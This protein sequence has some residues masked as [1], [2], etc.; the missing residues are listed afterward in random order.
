MKK[1][2]LSMVLATSMVATMLVGCGGN[3]G[4]ATGTTAAA[5]NNAQSVSMTFSWW[6]NQTRNE[7]TQAALDLYSQQNAGVTFDAQPAE[8]SD[9]WTK[10]STLAAGNSLPECLQMDYSYLEQYVSSSLLADL[11]PYVESGV[12]DVSK[13]DPG[14]LESGSVDGKLYAICAGVNAPSLLY[15]K[16]LMDEL[17]IKVKDNMT[18]DEFMDVARQ[19]YEKAGIKTDLPYSAGDNYLPYIMRSKGTTALF[20][21]DSLNVADEKAF[22]EYF[23]IYET[24]TKEGWIVGADIHAELTSNSVEQS[25]L[26][27]FS[28]E[29]TQSW[30]GFFWSNQ[31]S[32]MV[33]AAPEGMEIGI[34]TWPSNDPQKSNFLKP[35]QFF[36]VS[37][38]AGANEE[39]AVK[40]VNYMLNSVDANNILLGE[41]GVP[42]SSDV[43]AAISPLLD[44]TAQ[45]VT[46]YINDVVTPNC[47][48]ISPAIPDGANEVYDYCNQ[49]VDKVLYGEMTA[50]EAS[51]ELY[52]KGNESMGR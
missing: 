18:L 30:C 52:K 38:D 47:S 1:K 25:P 33:A 35:S 4:S 34:T 42:A 9:Y 20:N 6:G 31:L 21:D 19:V 29:A 49:L 22:V 28:S 23:S 5:G 12:L 2:L 11:T 45:T 17:G 7:R 32:A 15:N 37:R 44:E 50:E 40:V 16:T 27:Y 43:A 13:V 24:G 8:W 39:A 48:A 36:S 3:S 41:R 10:L 46:T 14:I 26:V 51:A